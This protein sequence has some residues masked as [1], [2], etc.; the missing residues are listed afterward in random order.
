MRARCV[1]IHR[2]DGRR[3]SRCPR[4]LI[5]PTNHHG[6]SPTSRFGTLRAGN[7]LNL[8]HAEGATIHARPCL[9]ATPLRILSDKT[10]ESVPVRLP[11]GLA[12]GVGAAGHIA[13]RPARPS[14]HSRPRTLRPT[15]PPASARIP[16]WLQCSAHPNHAS[17]LL[18]ALQNDPSPIR[19][20]LSRSANTY[21]VDLVAEDDTWMKKALK[22]QLEVQDP[23]AT[24]TSDPVAA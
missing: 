17:E 19:R 18:C 24:H 12:L 6:P 5:G 10:D 21:P 8:T 23:E 3:Q 1:A 15:P 7:F 20:H 16:K 2:G 22:R 4:W 9:R 11:H 14:P 13:A